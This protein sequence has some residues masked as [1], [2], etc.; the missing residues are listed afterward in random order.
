M[1]KELEIM[2]HAKKVLNEE[3]GIKEL[4]PFQKECI[5]RILLD[6]KDLFCIRNTGSGKSLC[7]QL[8]A[9]VLDG[10][11][12]V[13]SPLIALIDDQKDSLKAKGISVA[14]W[15]GNIDEE[16]IITLKDEL[17]SEECKYKLVYTTPE[18]LWYNREFFSSLDVSMLVIDEAHC[19]SVWGQTFRPAYRCIGK[20]IK[21]FK[22]RPLI[23]AFTATV[24]ERIFKDITESLG[25]DISK[26]D[27]I[28]TV[29]RKIDFPKNSDNRKIAL[30]RREEDKV[31][32]I[33][34]F[35]TENPY[36][37]TLVFCRS[38]EQ[39]E[40]IY[41]SLEK[42]ATE[43]GIENLN[44]DKYYGGNRHNDKEKR[45]KA[46]KAKEKVYRLFLNGNINVVIA[47]T[48]FGMGVDI[49]DIRCVGDN[50]NY[51]KM[52]SDRVLL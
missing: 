20:V 25:I 38:K 13:V 6:K 21:G 47:T 12:I 52:L 42:A 19:V 24:D 32:E 41:I 8:P 50:I 23:A 3:F 4:K 39:M 22:K 30:F 1:E 40:K 26:T 46:A 10:L 35:I 49:S 45:R 11:T 48:A 31:N 14:V 34:K 37:K 36:K 5:K 27:C 51:S 16:E 43:K 17:K 29:K 44:I 7:Y 9:L 2:E 15:H 28:G 18:T 33:C